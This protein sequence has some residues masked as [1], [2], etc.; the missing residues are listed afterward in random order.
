LVP[1]L[2]ENKDK[3]TIFINIALYGAETLALR[4]V[5]Q[6]LLESFEMWCW[7]RMGEISWADH[8]RN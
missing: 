8:V 2:P 5:G 7:R 3:K 1:S 6:K 4:A